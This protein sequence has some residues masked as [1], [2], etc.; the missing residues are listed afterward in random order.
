MCLKR[1]YLAELMQ[2][3]HQR[4][5]EDDEAQYKDV[6][7]SIDLLRALKFI[8]RAWKVREGREVTTKSTFLTDS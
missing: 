4:M 7:A 3:V 1:H 2:Y 6:V 5:D 8:N